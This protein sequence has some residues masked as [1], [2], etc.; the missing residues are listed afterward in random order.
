MDELPAMNDILDVLDQIAESSK[1][2]RIWAER[3]S[4]ERAHAAAAKGRP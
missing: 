2:I 4:A 3:E 1:E